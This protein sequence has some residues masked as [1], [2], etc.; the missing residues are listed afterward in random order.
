MRRKRHLLFMGLML[1]FAC[2]SLSASALVGS[3]NI[4]GTLT[5]TTSTIDFT[6][7][8]SPFPAEKARIGPGATGSFAGLDG[9]TIT[10][11]DLNTATEPVGSFAD[12]LFITF[13][14]APALP[15]LE[16][17]L[18][19]P[20]IYNPSGCLA[21]PPAAGQTCT[22]GVP[23]TGVP[24]PFN[25]V[26]NP[27]TVRPQASATFVFA[28]ES[29]DML[30]SWDGNFTSQFNVPFQ[31]ILQA[32]APGG[33]G[34]VTNTYSATIT[35]GPSSQVPE[36]GPIATLGLGLVLIFCSVGL[37]RYVR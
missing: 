13:D 35:V 36:P 24:S 20:G 32:F 18:I 1:G 22:P 3:F 5:A 4:A 15:G 37:R 8:D 2:G 7:N 28:G 27:G 19:F 29:S 23:I 6:G 12:Q 11:R 16:I 17:N 10:I 9:T 30:S 33:S 14:A 25:F 21:S 26:N 34:S 31:T